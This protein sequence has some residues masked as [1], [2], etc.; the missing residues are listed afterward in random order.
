MLGEAKTG[1]GDARQ[2]G[3]QIGKL[4][5]L[6]VG[7]GGKSR[8][9]DQQH[10]PLRRSIVFGCVR[11][12][13][14]LTSR[15][16]IAAT[17]AEAGAGM[18]TVSTALQWYTP[19]TEPHLVRQV[20]WLAGRCFIARLPGIHASDVVGNVAI[21]HWGINFPKADTAFRK[22]CPDRSQL[23]GSFGFDRIPS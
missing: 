20:S 2:R 8:F 12:L 10:V 6:P 15:G 5:H 7:R 4:L 14:S 23:R 21:H 9:G 13:Q 22:T 11:H 17:Q 3:Y 19:P 18:A 1:T 16:G